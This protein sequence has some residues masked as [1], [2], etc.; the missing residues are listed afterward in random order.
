MIV[1]PHAFWIFNIEIGLQILS[2]RESF[3]AT[4][5][6]VRPVPTSSASLLLIRYF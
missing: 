3:S 1:L 4:Y 5:G 2:T 6:Q